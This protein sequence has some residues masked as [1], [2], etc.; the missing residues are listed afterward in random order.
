[1][2]NLITILVLIASFFTHVASLSAQNDDPLDMTVL[3]FNKCT[4]DSIYR[5]SLNHIRSNNSILDDFLLEMT[6]HDFYLYDSFGYELFV[7][8]Q[9]KDLQISQD[10]FER[11]VLQW[12]DTINFN[13]TTK[14]QGDSCVRFTILKSGRLS[15]PNA[16]LKK[17]YFSVSPN[18]GHK[19]YTIKNGRCLLN[20]YNTSGQLLYSQKIISLNGTIELEAPPGVYYFQIE[21]NNKIETHRIV[22]SP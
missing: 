21:H 9:W 18:P 20:I 15:T 13:F 11:K 22:H 12:L 5:D 4:K 2:K 6:P 14:G 8:L 3:L 1:M 19:I 10:S 16:Y 7:D 17:N